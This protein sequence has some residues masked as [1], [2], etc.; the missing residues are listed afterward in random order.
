MSAIQIKALTKV[1]SGR[2]GEVEALGG[3]ELSVADREFVSVV[4][5]SGCG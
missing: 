2:R 5:A 4:G 3:V 1:F